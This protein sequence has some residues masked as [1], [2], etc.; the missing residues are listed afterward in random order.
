MGNLPV[1][2]STVAT[3]IVFVPD[4]PGYSICS[5]MTNPASASLSVGGRITLQ[6]A[7]GYPRG[8]RSIS[9]R[10]PSPWR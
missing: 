1:S 5:M 8:S 6:L 7:A 2:S 3:Q 4:I 9:L 10:R